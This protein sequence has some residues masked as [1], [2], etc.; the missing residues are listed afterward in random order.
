MIEELPQKKALKKESAL[1][2]MLSIIGLASLII[3][4]GASYYMQSNQAKQQANDQIVLQEFLKGPWN[5]QN[6]KEIDTTKWQG[7]TLV[8]N[9]WGSWCPPCVEEMPMLAD[10][11]KELNPQETLLIGL[12]IDSPSNIRDFLA[13]TPISYQIVLGGLYGSNWGKR[14]GNEQGALPYTVILSPEGQVTFS[15]LG[16]IT[17]DE[18]TSGLLIKK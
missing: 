3:G 4:L 15:K 16:K 8:I 10:V 7:K 11:S 12:G 13:K 18:L 5:D 1:L 17:K 9:F 2:I 14:L 6:A